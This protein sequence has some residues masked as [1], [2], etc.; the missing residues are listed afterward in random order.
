MVNL[1]RNKGWTAAKIGVGLIGLLLA[2]TCPVGAP[3]RAQDTVIRQI[4][5]FVDQPAGSSTSTIYFLDALSGLSTVVNVEN[6][7]HFTLVGDYVLYEKTH[8]GAIMTANR[9]GILSPHPFIQHT[10]DT[11]AIWWVT[12]PDRAAIAWV[13]VSAA[14]L[15]EAYIAWAD[16]RDLRQLPI[17]TPRPPLTLYPIALNTSRTQFFY[18]SA[19]PAT[20]TPYP[21]FEHIMMYDISNELFDTPPGEPN[22]L[23]GAAISSDG[24]ILARLETTQIAPEERGPFA[25]RIWDLPTNASFFIPPPDVDY[26]FAGDLVLNDFGTFAVYSAAAGVG[27]EANIVEE[28]YVLMMVDVVAQQQRV[29][30]GPGPVRYRPVSFID[31]DSALLLTSAA[32]SATYKLDL[33][34]GDLLQVSD[35]I[36]LGTITLTQ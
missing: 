5:V 35:R 22:C 7:Q 18:D 9:D 10:I 23:C 6:G 29:L 15:S 2:I 11:E 31:E 3:A 14:G 33:A 32:E 4:D 34:S 36:Y 8:T 25:L 17:A 30:A 19:H 24:R 1:S 21:A 12:S 28:A 26:R 13:R 20:D 16:G 27:A